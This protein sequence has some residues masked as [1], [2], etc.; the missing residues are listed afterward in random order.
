MLFRGHHVWRFQTDAYLAGALLISAF[1]HDGFSFRGGGTSKNGIEYRMFVVVGCVGD[2]DPVDN[3][4]NRTFC[5]PVSAFARQHLEPDVWV[6]LEEV[7]TGLLNTNIYR[8][9]TVEVAGWQW[10]G[11]FDRETVAERCVQARCRV[12]AERLI[13]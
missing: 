2:S 4:I 7:C 10:L 11:Y 12:F 1:S 3:D 13:C 5:G 6:K 9:M 8:R